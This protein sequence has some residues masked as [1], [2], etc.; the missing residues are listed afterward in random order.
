MGIRISSGIEP[1]TSAVL[2]PT[3]AGKKCVHIAFVGVGSHIID[4]GLNACGFGRE[5]GQ[6]EAKTT[7]D[8]TSV[9]LG[10]GLEASF[11]K[12]GQDEPI[13][14]VLDPGGILDLG[15]RPL[16]G[17]QERPVRLILSPLL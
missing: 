15:K 2:A 8:R 13:D 14:G 17:S 3:W 5:A 16:L 9:R 4:E 6:I 7:R 1:V 12:F 11:F 10:G